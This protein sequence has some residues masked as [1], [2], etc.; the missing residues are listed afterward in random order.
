M[1]RL[2]QAFALS[3]CLVSAA[4]AG[5]VTFG[6][7]AG[8]SIPNLRDNG[9]NELSEGWSSRVAPYFGAYADV[10]VTP[11][12]SVQAEVNYAAQG[13]KKDGLQP[14][15][16]DTSQLPV[17]P[18]TP[19]YARFKNVA[20]LDYIEIPVLAKFHFGA[21]RRLFV[22]LGPYV[23]ILI[24]AKTVTSGTSSIYLDARGDQVLTLPDGPPYFG[25]EVPPQ[26]F[27]ATTDGKADLHTFSWGIQ[28]G[29][30]VSQALGPGTASLEVRGGVGLANI[31]KD[32]ATNGKNSTG[33][34]VVAL[35]Y[36]LPMGGR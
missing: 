6:A 36:S 35:G 32:T 13:G 20:K 21:A 28:G 19:L 34:L 3:C 24:S 17:P 23:G 18:G 8:S 11:T 7:H 10:T 12:F 29:A 31:Q 33:N 5:T 25:A 15:I 1:S 4:S 14:I 27:G 9:G 16:T 30:G 22:D 2:L 26:D